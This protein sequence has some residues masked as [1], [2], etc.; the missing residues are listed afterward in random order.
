[1][2]RQCLRK[3]TKHVIK[4]PR[5]PGGELEYTSPLAWTSHLVQPLPR[6]RDDVV[7]PIVGA[8]GQA[9]WCGDGGETRAVGGRASNNAHEQKAALRRIPGSRNHHAN[10]HEWVC[11][12]HSA[13]WLVLKDAVFGSELG[14]VAGSLD[15]DLVS[16][17]GQPV[18]SAIA[19]DW[20]TKPVMMPV[21][22]IASF[23]L[24]AVVGPK[25]GR[26][27]WGPS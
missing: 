14:A 4:T 18:Q 10:R 7:D 24:C 21:S 25:D 16:G 5:G 8:A 13:S 19:E 11:G 2:L 3:S 1:M 15:N 9:A 17:V 12:R 23:F 6:S 22:S 26:V 27:P 20:V